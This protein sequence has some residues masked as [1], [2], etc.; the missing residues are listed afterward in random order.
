MK[1]FKFLQLLKTAAE[2]LVVVGIPAFLVV[3]IFHIHVVAGILA[4][5]GLIVAAVVL[6]ELM[7]KDEEDDDE[8]D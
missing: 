7:D 3:E 6:N 1:Q 2:M 8:N 4:C 5:L